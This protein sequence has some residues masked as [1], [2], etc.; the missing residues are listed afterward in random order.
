MINTALLQSLERYERMNRLFYGIISENGMHPYDWMKDALAMAMRRE[1][2][3]MQANK[4]AWLSDM[5]RAKERPE[6]E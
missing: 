3:F 1:R 2:D 4:E 6:G 5:E